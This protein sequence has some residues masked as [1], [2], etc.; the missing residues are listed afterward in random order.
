M[1]RIIDSDE[2]EDHRI[3]V[4]EF[5]QGQFYFLSEF[6]FFF[7]KP[8]LFLSFQNSGVQQLNKWGG[9]IDDPEK[10]FKEID[11]DGGGMILFDEFAA[12]AIKRGLDLEDD[13]DASFEDFGNRGASNL[14][15]NQIAKGP[16]SPSKPTTPQKR[17]AP[18]TLKKKEEITAQLCFQKSG[19]QTTIRQKLF[20]RM[21]LKRKDCLS[22]ADLERGVKMEVKLPEKFDVKQGILLAFEV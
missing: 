14:S 7:L 21:D 3:S 6:Y 10:T 5:R 13:D 17:T 4:K 12:W 20:K 19:E 2:F 16:K 22:V 1:F 8:N 9:K 15:R 11:V 18:T